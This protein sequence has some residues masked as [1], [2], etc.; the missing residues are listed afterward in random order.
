ML[1][2][3]GEFGYRAGVAKLPWLLVLRVAVLVALAASAALLS[4]YLGDAPSFC[5]AASG[6][7]AVRASPYSHISW[8]EGSFVPLPALGVLGF[9]ALYAASLLSRRLTVALAVV[10]GVAAAWLLAVQA[11]VLQQFCWLCVTT[12]VSAIIAA[13]A[14]VLVARTPA[15]GWDVAVPGD[16]TQRLSGWAWWALGALSLAA[17]LVWPLVKSAPAVPGKVLAYYAPGKLN[18]VE[19]ADFQCPACR[20]YHEVLKPILQRYGERVHFVRLHKPLASHPFAQDAAQAAV[21]AER[22]GKLEPMADALFTAPDLS[23]S[24]IDRLAHAVGLDAKAFETCMMDPETKARVERESSLL[25]P[26]E[27]EGLPTT[28]IGGKRLLGVQSPEAVEDALQRAARG[29][30]TSGIAWFVYLPLLAS[31]AL[32]ILRAGL[33]RPALT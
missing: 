26:P 11:F 21:C 18:V 22:L 33:R 28:Y 9:A 6:C 13:S 7:G 1:P 23:P 24:A 5:S 32:L 30:R 16:V 17:P 4:D 10:G 31:C 29:E 27:L 25:V 15:S 19:F 14:A 2:A 12:D 8:G 3:S 20:R